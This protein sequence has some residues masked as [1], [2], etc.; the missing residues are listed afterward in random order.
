MT[1]DIRDPHIIMCDVDA[2]RRLQIAVYGDPDAE[3][4]MLFD[5]GSFG[6]YA[7]GHNLA[8]ELAARGWHVIGMTRAGMYGSDPLPAGQTP[9]P[10]FHVDDMARLLDALGIR[11]RLVLAGH[12]MAGVRVHLAGHLMEDRLRGLVLLDAVCPSLM[13]SITWAGWVAWA[14]A[15]GQAG[16]FV[17]TSALG[18]LVEELHPNGL[19]LSGRPREDKLASVSSDAHLLNSAAEVAAT[20]RRSFAE[21]I[22]P[23]LDLP[24]FFATATPVSQG[25][26]KLV[27]A[28]RDRGSWVR[29]IKPRGVGH[30]SL[31]APEHVPDLADGADAL[32]AAGS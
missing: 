10:G 30:V 3:R 5:P 7:D 4:V 6:I 11:K 32:F 15:L 26:T 8:A 19:K 21:R 1:Q 12:S 16:A 24:A 14:R 20:E 23:A 9:L 17:A 31:L 27:E 22:E 2:G 25:T 28:Y 18:P 13:E 29:R